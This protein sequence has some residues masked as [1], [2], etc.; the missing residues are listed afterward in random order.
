MLCSLIVYIIHPVPRF[1]GRVR[2]IGIVVLGY[3]NG[4]WA[5]GK[6]RHLGTRLF[7]VLLA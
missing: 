2:V 3:G 5:Q 4:T 6:G 1:A 7:E